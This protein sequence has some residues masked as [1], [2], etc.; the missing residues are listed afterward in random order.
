MTLSENKER[1]RSIFEP[2][3]IELEPVDAPGAA[4]SQGDGREW[5]LALARFGR[6]GFL[7]L[8][9]AP[10]ASK[11]RF[12]AELAM[13][14]ADKDYAETLRDYLS[15]KTGGK[16]SLD[17]AKNPWALAAEELSEDAA[18]A[19]V[20]VFRRVAEHIQAAEEGARPSVLADEFRGAKQADG[21]S[22]KSDD[23][24][25]NES[26]STSPF[27]TIGGGEAQAEPERD[28]PESEQRASDE[29]RDEGPVMLDSFR[30]SVRD[31]VIHAGLEISPGE[32]ERRDEARLLSALTKVLE[33]R[34]DLTLLSRELIR[35]EVRVAAR[36][37]LKEETGELAHD[38]GRYF[39]RLKK[40]GVLGMPLMAVLDP[41]S[42]QGAESSRARARAARREPTRARRAE[43]RRGEESSA[44]ASGEVVFSFDPS[45]GDDP[46]GGEQR[47]DGLRPGDFTDPRIRR[48][49]ATTEL[50]D[51]VLRHPG[52]SDR[53]MRQVL[54]ILL[55]IDYVDAEKLVKQAPCLIAWSVSHGRAREFKRV[56]EGAGGRVTLVEPDSLH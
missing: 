4:S 14:D 55:D 22:D 41:S 51:V 28:A 7:R 13:P 18:A 48:E 49:D 30:V 15:E 6:R 5:F 8:L 36:A 39:E 45:G 50:V 38:L 17:T 52:Y 27:E 46:R 33:L 37:N 1:W 35:G 24:A 3:D 12:I 42:P 11:M 31:G 16:W 26:G 44:P 43:A 47:A 23:Q 32:L 54:S 56:I 40:F 21:T 34:Y 9:V 53:N 10:G 19:S 29:T 2:L 20:E 25:G